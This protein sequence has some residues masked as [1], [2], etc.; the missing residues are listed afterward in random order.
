LGEST[1]EFGNR[2]TAYLDAGVAPR[3]HPTRWIAQPLRAYADA[4]DE[5]DAA[6]DRDR[7]AMIT[8]EPAERTVQ[9]RRIE[10]AS[11]YASRGELRPQCAGAKGAQPVID[12]AHVDTGPCLR[13]QRVGEPAPDFVI[14][15]EVA[16]EQN[17]A[18]GIANGV[19]PS[20]EILLCVEQQA[21]RVAID[22][23]RPRGPRERAIGKL[24][25]RDR[26]QVSLESS[27]RIAR[28]HRPCQCTGNRARL[29]KPRV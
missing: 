16:L 27:A 20:R 5:A 19:V 10:R 23:I 21:N 4:G 22:R 29:H 8:A 12:H 24:A 6:I 17:R 3:L 28:G 9:A 14:V 26:L 15:E 11:L 18:L 2:G 1:H 25:E 13:R 7:L